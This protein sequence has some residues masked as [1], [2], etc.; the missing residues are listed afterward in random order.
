MKSNEE[1]LI[2]LKKEL[3]RIG[4]TS[5]E[6]YDKL[7]KDGQLHSRLLGSFKKPDHIEKHNAWIL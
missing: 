1:L 2:K 3:Q 6:V 5:A 4:S 7:R